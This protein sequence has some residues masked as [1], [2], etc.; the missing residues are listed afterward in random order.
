MTKSRKFDSDEYLNAYYNDH[1]YPHIH[2]NIYTVAMSRL[3]PE[4]PIMDLG[5][6]YG[7]LSAHLADKGHHAYAVEPDPTYD[8]KQ[9]KRDDITYLNIPVADSTLEELS[10]VIKD[11]HIHTII[12][13]RVFPEICDFNGIEFFPRLNK[14]FSESGITKIILEG[15]Y[16]NPHAVNPLKNAELEAKQFPDYAMVYDE[17]NVVVLEKK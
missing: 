1:K 15:R 2:S 6:C 10:N 17:H 16:R 14:M 13:R 4:E 9:I 3:E 7:L 12:A 5:A 8:L 11:N